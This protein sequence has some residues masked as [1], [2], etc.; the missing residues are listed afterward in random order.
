MNIQNGYDLIKNLKINEKTQLITGG[1]Q[2]TSATEIILK[3]MDKINYVIRGESE[4]VINKICNKIDKKIP[5]KDELGLGYLQNGKLVLNQKQE[6]LENLN[7]LCPYD[8]DIFDNQVFLK[9][10]KGKVIKGIDYEISRGCIYSCSYCVETIIQKYYGFDEKSEKTGAIKNFKKYLR[11]KSAKNA[12]EEIKYLHKKHGIQLFRC[13]DTNFLTIDRD[14]LFE[15]AELIDSSGFKIK[16]YIETRPEGINKKSIEL[17]KKLKIHGVGMGIEAASESFRQEN[18]NRFANQEKI[19]EAFKMLKERGFLCFITP[20]G[21]RGP[22]RY[23]ELWDMM[24]EK[25]ILY[26]HVYTDMDAKRLF[27]ILS[28]FD[29][30]IIQNKLNSKKTLVIDEHDKKH[31]LD[32]KK[33]PFLPNYAYKEMFSLLVDKTDKK[34]GLDIIF[35]T[36]YH[37]QWKHM[38]NFKKGR[39]KYPVIHGIKQKEIRFMYSSTNKKGHFGVPK[40]ILSH[41]K[42]QYKYPE[43]NDYNGLYGMSD[44]CFGIPI[45]SKKEGDMILKAI[46]SPKFKKILAGAKWSLFQTPHQMFEHFK[47]DFYKL[48]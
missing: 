32:L 26:I 4:I 27:N 9:K 12:F 33:W 36:V 37:N 42:E 46:H 1:L 38:S 29:V 22:G 34:G 30:Y 15:L 35:D 3:K 25:Q 2:A 24:S 44:G 19:I 45:K 28:R 20:S 23:S 31:R 18:L 5:F 6:I 17:L 8:Y 10:Y 39:F 41:N 21:W 14:V 47:K 16:F 40:V 43:L 13:Q 11:C 7:D 48:L